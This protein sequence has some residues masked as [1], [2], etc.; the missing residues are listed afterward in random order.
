M[1][2][3]IRDKELKRQQI[4]VA[5]AGHLLNEGFHNSG[6]RALAR[7]AGVS[8]RMLMYYFANKEELVAAA[9]LYL[10]ERL[11]VQLN[12]LVPAARVSGDELINTLTA[13]GRTPEVRAF[14][15]LWFEMVGPAIRG[16]S[17]F[18]ATTE[19]ILTNWEDW[20]RDKLGPRRAHQARAVLARL[21]GE[22]MLSLLEDTDTRPDPQL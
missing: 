15:A 12:Q 7:S 17:P 4:I 18:R 11:S 9:L 10:A 22:L 6:L 3:Q 20:I 8:D 14:L 21:E 13:A 19:Q 16:H 1:S 5:V 2:A